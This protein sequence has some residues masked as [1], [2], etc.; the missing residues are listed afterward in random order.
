LLQFVGLINMDDILGGTN[1]C[2]INKGGSTIKTRSYGE[3]FASAGLISGKAG[4]ADWMWLIAVIVG[5]VSSLMYFLDKEHKQGL[6]ALSVALI[7]LGLLV[8]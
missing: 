8:S 6:L 4:F 7:A 5:A 3:M 1:V 2:K